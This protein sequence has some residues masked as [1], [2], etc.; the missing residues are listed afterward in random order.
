MA[1]N[2]NERSDDQF[3]FTMV[4]ELGVL[5]M[6]ESGW[7]R[8]VNIVSWNG[9]PSKVD[10]RD[11]SPGHKRMSKGVTLRVDE[12]LRMTQILIERLD[13]SGKRRRNLPPVRP[14]QN[15]AQSGEQRQPQRPQ[16][17]HQQQVQP[18]PQPQAQSE[19]REEPRYQESEQHYRDNN[20]EITDAPMDE[21]E[22]GAAGA[23]NLWDEPDW[24]EDENAEEE[25][26]QEPEQEANNIAA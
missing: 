19:F 8:E 16:R 10:I 21:P 12:A 20:D 7:N 5:A 1:E 24:S 9:R 14:P 4:E 17:Q 23:D 6:H 22:I 15:R 18:H 25:F 2:I 26:G 11:W 13:P 3:F